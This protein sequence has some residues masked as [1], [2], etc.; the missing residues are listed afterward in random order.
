MLQKGYTQK[1]IADTIG[2]DK[3][4]VCRKFGVI[5]MNLPNVSVTKD[6]KLNVKK[7]VLQSQ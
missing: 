3:S 2:K 7:F 6:T 4:T 5:V 1:E